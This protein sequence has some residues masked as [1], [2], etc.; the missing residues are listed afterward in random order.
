M[1]SKANIQQRVSTT[2]K[3][4]SRM[5]NLA[6]TARQPLA[7]QA[8]K[9]VPIAS[10]APKFEEGYQPGKRYDP[11]AERNAA[12]KLKAQYK[13]ERKGA[14]RELRKDNRFL[15]GEKAKDQAEKDREYTAKMRRAEGSIT[16][17]RAEEKEMEREKA[18][19]K[20]RAG[21]G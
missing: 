8:H 2:A 19:E 17:E 5:L 3:T 20:R 6:I 11:D 1:E 16:V 15:A 7:L 9:P 13:Q 10:H 18:R 14:I 4:L 12:S 21:R